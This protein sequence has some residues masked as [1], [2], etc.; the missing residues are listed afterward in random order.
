MR[1]VTV[2]FGIG[3][4]STL[5]SF[6]A[7]Q[8]AQD[9]SQETKELL[10]RVIGASVPLYPE[11]ARETRIE[12]DVVLRV[13][14]DG[15]RV[16]AVDAKTGHRML[17]NGAEENVQTWKFATHN[18]TSFEV[19][20]HYKLLPVQCDLECNCEPKEKESVLLR[21][22]TTVDVSAAALLIC[23][24]AAEI[25]RKRSLFARFFHLH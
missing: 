19:T 8:A 4:I 24:P 21:F 1:K 10:P 9:N 23:D 22:P 12:G 5:P 25:R 13:F 18:P 14:T 15:K 16:S 2:R 3:L 20:F 11:L 17:V 7:C 6:S